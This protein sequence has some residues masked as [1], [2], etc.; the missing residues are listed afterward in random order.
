MTHLVIGEKR[1]MSMRKEAEEHVIDL[2][3][4]ETVGEDV[5]I[6][7]LKNNQRR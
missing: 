3:E 7:A 2:R 1:K 5:L 4:I 6:V